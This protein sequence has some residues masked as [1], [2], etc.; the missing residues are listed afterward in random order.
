MQRERTVSAIQVVKSNPRFPSAEVQIHDRVTELTQRTP[1]ERIPEGTPERL[2]FAVSLL[3]IR[4]EAYVELVTDMS[5]QDAFVVL[6]IEFK[7]RSGE[8]Y[9][10]FPR[11]LLVESLPE[12]EQR[13]NHWVTEGYRRLASLQEA[14]H[15]PT[16]DSD[17]TGED[18]AQRRRAFI[19]PLLKEK[20]FS[21][22][23]WASEAGV[24][25]SVVYDYLSG[26]SDPRPDS[27]KA[28]AEVLGLK[29][30]ALPE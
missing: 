22:S 2:T 14:P 28:L 29:P 12:L 6:M 10:G 30:S 20:G 13:F 18:A 24:D 19:L 5:S 9:S 15:T 21:R 8:A 7:L 27:K 25:P 3:D 17:H 26:D 4:A 1:P 23:K 11:A 16:S